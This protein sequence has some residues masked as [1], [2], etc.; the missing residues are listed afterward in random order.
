MPAAEQGGPQPRALQLRPPEATSATGFTRVTSVRE[1]ADGRLLVA[2]PGE[3]RLAVIDWRTG[4]IA[5]VSRAGEGPGEYRTVGWLYPLRGDTTLLTDAASRKWHVIVGATVRTTLVGTRDND[6]LL[7]PIL[8]GT[9]LQNHFLAVNGYVYPP[10]AP[11]QMGSTGADSIQV[12]LALGATAEAAPLRLDT[13]ARIGGR[14][15]F[16]LVAAAGSSA[17]ARGPVTPPC[18]QYATEDLPFLFPDGWVAIAFRNP[19]R[20]DW[21]APDGRWIKG[22]P[23]PGAGER[24]A[25]QDKCAALK[26]FPFRG[27]TDCDAAAVVAQ[28]WPTVLPPFLRH[29]S[30]RPMVAPSSAT[31]FATPEGNLVIRRAPSYAS[32][33]TRYDIVDRRG[34]LA[35]TLTLP[36]NEAIIGFGARSIYTLTTDDSDLQWIRK[37]PWPGIGG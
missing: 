30:G 26:G 9:D 11:Y 1:L 23:L 35:A 18:S 10:T 36:V 28:T 7:D 3:R 17:S 34:S 29:L 5:A 24:P 13:I 12:L 16:P 22:A 14:S 37:H 25:Q 33:A 19:Y 2:D 31:V 15:C 8:S 32:P 6:D 4:A 27:A 20:V 21:R